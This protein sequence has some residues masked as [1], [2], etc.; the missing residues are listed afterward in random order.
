MARVRL[1]E[2][3]VQDLNDLSQVV[4]AARASVPCGTWGNRTLTAWLTWWSLALAQIR[5]ES[6][7]S[8]SLPGAL[9]GGAYETLYRWT[10]RIFRQSICYE[11]S[12]AE[13]DAFEEMWAWL[14]SVTGTNARIGIGTVGL[15][16]GILGLAAAG[17]MYRRGR[18]GKR[19]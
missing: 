7:G 5:D 11:P 19:R 18:K 3:E 13:V 15:V 8:Q 10:D 17:L 12:P 1:T 2:A 6:D 16:V 9:V 14:R 4:V